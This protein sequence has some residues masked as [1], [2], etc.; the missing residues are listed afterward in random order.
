[1]YEFGHR[2]GHALL[3][4]IVLAE[5]TIA[6]IVIITLAYC[7]WLLVVAAVATR[8]MRRN[9]DGSENLASIGGSQ[10][11]RFCILVPAH[12]EEE[13]IAP[14]LDA[15]RSV[16]YDRSA[17]RIVV[18]ADNCSDAT[19]EIAS[20]V[21]GVEVWE[22]NDTSQMGKP[23]ALNWAMSRL[24]S[25][26]AFD[27]I[28][29]MDADTIMD[30]QFLIAMDNAYVRAGGGKF[31]AQGWYTV[32]N[33][34]ANWRTSLMTG[35]LGL[36]HYVRPLA[37][38]TLGLSVGLK[39]NGMCFGKDVLD[40]ISWC[41]ECLTEDIDLGL[42]LIE[43]HGV[44]VRFVPDAIVCAL[45]PTS[46]S[47]SVTQRR[48]WELGRNAIRRR[49]VRMFLNA[50]LSG[51]RVAGDLAFDQLIPPVA[52]LGTLVIM[53]C[54]LAAFVWIGGVHS[55]AM[56]MACLAAVASFVMYV[57]G[58][59]RVS[60][61]PKQAYW[62][63]LTTPFYIVWKLVTVSGLLGRGSRKI[64]TDRSSVSKSKV[65]EEISKK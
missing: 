40:D 65:P 54:V 36:V 7:L 2:L 19:I 18:I 51:D 25:E 41:S 59:F 55:R 10:T 49:A 48:R 39:G 35:A 14:T 33:S 1:M 27:V 53:W 6:F 30:S 34:T 46:K 61:A 13:V 47:G 12:N 50:G 56:P 21:E 64:R 9:E 23:S 42:D 15:L 20:R 5:V 32:L 45:M 22:R 16:Q 58:G 52:E 3:G 11:T 60:Q 29:I 26:D 57:L 8:R 44:R 38:E 17:F 62:A 4:L 63:L 28:A 37:R 31:A 43:I 24:R